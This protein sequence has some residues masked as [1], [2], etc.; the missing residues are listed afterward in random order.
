MFMSP[1]SELIGRK[2]V[3]LISMGLFCIFSIPCAVAKSMAV[4]IVFRFLAGTAASVPMCELNRRRARNS[5]LTG[6]SPIRQRRWIH[7]RCC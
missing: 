1:L 4:L 2:L 5:W 3:Y 6:L 7:C